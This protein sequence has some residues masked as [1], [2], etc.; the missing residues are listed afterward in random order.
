MSDVSEEHQVWSAVPNHAQSD[1][2][3]DSL[4]GQS[5]DLGYADP[6]HPS[7]GFRGICRDAPLACGIDEAP[8]PAYNLLRL[9]CGA[10]DDS[11]DV[12]MG[13]AFP[14]EHNLESLGG[15]SFRKGCY[16]G[17]E[18]TARTFHTGKTR[19]RILPVLREDDLAVVSQEDLEGEFGETLR[20][21]V[22]VPATAALL[23]R[24]RPASVLGAPGSEVRDPS[25]KRA[26]GK[27][28]S[29]QYNLGLAHLRLGPAMARTARLEVEGELI[30][31][32]PPPWIP[33]E[34]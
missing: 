27:L 18:L 7:L 19:K 11:I 12:P 2:T 5:G 28:R 21:L 13:E 16:L 22:G 8:A 31:P 23:P 4:V 29:S 15:V 3:A 20:H 32:V 17:Q 1:L 24:L 6:R 34:D 30:K 14:L 10:P 9:A 26:V 25:Q 33:T